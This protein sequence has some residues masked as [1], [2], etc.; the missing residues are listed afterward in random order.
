MRSPVN[1][2]PGTLALVGAIAGILVAASVTGLV[3]K[4]RVRSEAGRTT[5]QNLNARTRAWWVMAGVFGVAIFLGRGAVCTLFGLMSFL[6]LREMLTLAPTR[7][8][9]HH[10]LFWAMFVIVPIQYYLVYA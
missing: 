1:A 8:A 4:F 2:E 9:D 10:T 3:L 6:A 5:V 7:R